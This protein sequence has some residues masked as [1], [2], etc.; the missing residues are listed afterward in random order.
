MY[1][2]FLIFCALL[3]ALVATFVGYRFCCTGND[4]GIEYEM[5]SLTVTVILMLLVFIGPIDWSLIDFNK[6][7]V[8]LVAI[9]VSIA[10][11]MMY[12]HVLMLCAAWGEELNYPADVRKARRRSRRQDVKT[13]IT[14]EDI[15]RALRREEQQEY[16]QQLERMLDWVDGIEWVDLDTDPE[17]NLMAEPKQD[18]SSQPTA[19]TQAPRNITRP[20]AV[21]TV[22]A[23]V[24]H[25]GLK[26]L[27]LVI[28]A[29]RREPA[30]LYMLRSTKLFA[31]LEIVGEGD[32][33]RIRIKGAV[34]PRRAHR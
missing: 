25:L 9:A 17:L 11:M 26:D 13:V 21:S 28:T 7:W 5:C 31:K 8:G 15:R 6:P 27:R 3:G 16:D 20:N 22:K 12:Y 30:L 1:V 33:R 29:F 24:R 18:M 2:W 19:T 4:L 32:Q 10:A 34:Y 14:P 23:L